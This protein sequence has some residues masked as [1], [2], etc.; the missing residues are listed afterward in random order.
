MLMGQF[1]HCRDDAISALKIKKDDAQMWLILARSRYFVEK[2]AEGLKYAKQG[3]AH[4]PS[5][6]KLLHMESLFEFALENERK[7]AEAI[8]PME[9]LKQDKKLEIY[10]NMR[11]KQ[12]KVGKKLNYI[13]DNVGVDFKIE[14]DKEDRLH[15]PVL[16]LYDEFMATDFVQDWREDQ[17][18]RSQLNPIFASQPP[19]DKEGDYT[20]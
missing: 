7:A 17:T 1:G 11:G 16:I 15:F 8:K 13:P 14:V 2:W 12:I 3:L 20:M 4:V 10:R 19:W 6:K 9:N 5:D 18:I